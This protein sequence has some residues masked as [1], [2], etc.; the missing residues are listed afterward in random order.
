MTHYSV[1]IGPHMLS[2]PCCWYYRLAM[3]SKKVLLDSRL[4]PIFSSSYY[5]KETCLVYV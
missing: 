3:V 2:E 1:N 5:M 4:T